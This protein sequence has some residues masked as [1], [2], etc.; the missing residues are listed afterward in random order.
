VE[1][2][3]TKSDAEAG[4]LENAKHIGK[5]IDKYFEWNLSKFPYQKGKNILDVGCGPCTYLD[6]ILSYEPALYYAA[7]YSD[8]FISEVNTLIRGKDNCRAGKIDLLD[9]SSIVNFFDYNFDFVMCFDVIEHI[10]DDVKALTNIRRIM[11]R[12]GKGKLFVKVPALQ[13]IY[14]VN[15]YSIG[16]YRRYSRKS[17]KTAVEKAGLEVTE[18]HYHNIFGIIPWWIIGRVLKRKVALSEKERS[19][20]DCLVWFFKTAEKI[21]PPPLGLSLNCVCK[22]K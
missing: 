20:F 15:D 6:N 14:G 21:I 9:A 3:F 1:H 7:D 2:K 12:T 5:N 16:H 22:L 8:V 11:E 10:E 18:I 4:M 13:S 17:L 19:T